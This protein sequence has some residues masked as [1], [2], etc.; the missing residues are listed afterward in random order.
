MP[1]GMK[2]KTGFVTNSSSTN[3]MIAYKDTPIKIN[4]ATSSRY[5]WVAMIAEHLYE[6]IRNEDHAYETE[7][8]EIISD[9]EDVEHYIRETYSYYVSSRDGWYGIHEKPPLESILAC[10]DGKIREEYETMMKY[11]KHG[12]TIMN[13]SVGYDDKFLTALI[14][15]LNDSEKNFIIISEYEG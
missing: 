9:A 13:K 12:Y 2:I 5:P 1:A 4:K 10:N 7:E 6:F 8:A 11:I 15:G 14:N 3:Y